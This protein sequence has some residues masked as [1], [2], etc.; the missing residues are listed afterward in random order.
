MRQL[1]I[2]MSI[3]VF[4]QGLLSE[5][6]NSSEA[7]SLAKQQEET[8][9]RRQ[10]N[11][12][13]SLKTRYISLA[14]HAWQKSYP[15]W[16]APSRRYLTSAPFPMPPSLG[17]TCSPI[18]VEVVRV[19]QVDAR[20]LHC[21]P[22]SLD[23]FPYYEVQARLLKSW[24]LTDTPTVAGWIPA[25][26]GDVVH[27]LWVARRR[28][29][30]REESSPQD[31]RTL[32]IWRTGRRYLILE[33]MGY[34]YE[35]PPE[36]R[37]HPDPEKRIE[38]SKDN[39]PSLDQVWLLVG[40]FGFGRFVGVRG[41]G[42]AI[43]RRANGLCGWIPASRE[44]YSVVE[45]PPEEL[46]RLL[47]EERAVLKPIAKMDP[48]ERT[49]TLQRWAQSLIQDPNS[50]LWRKYRAVLY[51]W[52][53]IAPGASSYISTPDS[54]LLMRGWAPELQALGF[55]L[56]EG[57]GNLVE[58]KEKRSFEVFRRA[59]EALYWYVEEG[60]T[61]E[62]RYRAA[63][64]LALMLAQSLKD[65]ELN[66]WRDGDWNEEAVSEWLDGLNARLK[67][68]VNSEPD[69]AVRW[70]LQAGE[71]EVTLCKLEREALKRGVDL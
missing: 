45:S 22:E 55:E 62:V 35:A 44:N 49:P 20:V 17:L 28:N 23:D 53:G 13:F 12:L 67:R 59:W 42:D 29:L 41:I 38:F 33:L 14:E 26:V 71:V 40:D 9:L 2:W 54:L 70:L 69:Q 4:V 36:K 57:T 68:R 52:A 15:S 27:L 51:F 46:F 61:V 25:R 31:L 7:S 56:I 30:S 43:E 21:Y 39:P 50:A 5:Q 65:A 47:D 34:A 11:E 37:D 1:V 32:Q 10:R 16:A 66:H 58:E 60:S 48:K 3:F 19:Q 18:Y 8:T 6:P 64:I 24:H 63:R